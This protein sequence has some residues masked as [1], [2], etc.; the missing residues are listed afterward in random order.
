LNKKL[1]FFLS[2]L[3][4]FISFYSIA[5]TSPAML[6]VSATNKGIL[7]P[8]VSLTSNLDILTIPSPVVSLM[9]YNTSSAGTYPN[10]VSPNFYFW[11]GN[12]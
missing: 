9:V 12:K 4:T 1:F 6:D 5:Q 11:D 8:R 10:H 7:I 3:L 2:L